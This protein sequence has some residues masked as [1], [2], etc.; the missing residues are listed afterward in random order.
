VIERRV[1]VVRFPTAAVTVGVTDV[2][3]LLLAAG[4]H[5][6]RELLDVSA[7]REQGLVPR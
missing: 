3:A 4:A 6:T 2:V 5:S 1:T 7:V